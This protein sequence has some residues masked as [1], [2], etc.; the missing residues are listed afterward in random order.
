MSR[1]FNHC[2]FLA[3]AG[4]EVPFLLIKRGGGGGRNQESAWRRKDKENYCMNNRNAR[5]SCSKVWLLQQRQ[6]GAGMLFTGWISILTGLVL[7]P[8]VQTNNHCNTLMELKKINTQ[9]FFFIN[10]AN[11]IILRFSITS[12]TH[13]TWSACLYMYEWVLSP[14]CGKISELY[15]SEVIGRS[16]KWQ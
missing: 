4:K 12:A 5:L 10:I 6:D 15:L 13:S 16:R 11:F 2:S 8:E 3:L 7:S 9:F 14:S 1:N